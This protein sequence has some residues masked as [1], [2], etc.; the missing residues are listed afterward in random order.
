MTT[1]APPS[2]LLSLRCEMT[3]C[4]RAGRLLAASITATKPHGHRGRK[5]KRELA[6]RILAHG[7]ASREKVREWLLDNA[8]LLQTAEK[9]AL[10][11]GAG[12]HRFPVAIDSVTGEAPRIVR[13]AQAYLD[14]VH[15]RFSEESCAAFLEGFQAKTALEMGEIWAL[16]PALQLEVLA[17]LDGSASEAWPELAAEPPAQYLATLRMAASTSA[18]PGRMAS[19]S[20]GA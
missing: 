9:E 17:R 18:D 2:D 10:E 4:R 7:R 11:L 15:N 16:K 3:E 12:L 6:L 5:R 8:R 13:I 19:S 20:T 14:Q 1:Q